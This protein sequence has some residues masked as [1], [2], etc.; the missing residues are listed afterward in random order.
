MA[1]DPPLGSTSPAVLLDNATRLDEL[2]NGPAAD[3]PDRGGD[4]LYSWRQ[5]M[6]KNDEVRQNLIPLS[7]QYATLAAAQADIVNIPEGSTAY[8]RSPDD[9]ALAIEVMNVGG[10]LQPTG[11]KMP[12]QEYVESVDEYVTTRLFSEV[13]PGIPFLLQDEESGVIMFGEDSGATHVPGLSLK[14]GSDLA[15]SVT[16]IPGVAHV[17]LDENGN[18][19]RWVDDSGE[20]HDASPGSG[21]EPTPVAVSSPVISPQ[22]YDNALVSEIGY[23]GWINNVAVKFGRDYF[24]SGVRLGTTGPERI[25]GNLAICRRQGERG[26]FGCYEFGPRAAVLGDTAST[27]DDHDAP[28]ILLDTRAGAEVPIQIFQSDHSGANVWLRKWSSQ[29]LDPANIS[30]PE[31]VSDTS[32]MTYAQSYRNPFN[33]NEILVFARRGSTN[34]ARWVAHHSTDNGRTWQSNAFIG[35]SDLYMT[36][37]QSVDGNAIHL[38]IQQHPRSTDTRVLYMKIK[39]SDKSLINYSGITALPDIMTYGYIDPFLNGIPDVVFESSLPTNT[40]RLFE[41]K[42]DGVSILFLIAEF[43]ASNYSYRR[44]KMSQFSGGTPVIHDIGDCGSPM[45]N[46]DA[47]F[48]VPGGTIISATDVLVCNWVKIPALGQLTRYVYDGSA[49]NGTLLDEVKDGRKI[50]RPLVFREYYQDNGIL[51]YHDTNTVV[52]LRGTYNA[53]R[54][55]D[56][57]A[58]LINI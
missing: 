54:D 42:D 22:V 18:V 28:S 55:F 3:V 58:V 5:M 46:D 20:T 11:R 36:T 16:Q 53:Y 26:K 4:P 1:F 40:K 56:L 35:G 44:M 57:D 48:Y 23:N 41:V 51:K 34:S 25:L 52:Y 38:A 33:Q 39:W 30:G 6:A 24:F 9:S 50:C 49:W 14:Y 27:D 10:T 8:Y 21:A 31:V 45:N 13:L 32:N 19:L 15:Y 2:V 12:S 47:T 37:C 17:E 43:N 7:K 29:T